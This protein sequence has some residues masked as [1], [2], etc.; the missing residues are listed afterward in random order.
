MKSPAL[1]LKTAAILLFTLGVLLLCTFYGPHQRR[2][3][4]PPVEREVANYVD[5]YHL[6][7]VARV[8]GRI[9]YL[10]D[11]RAFRSDKGTEAT[12]DNYLDLAV[13]KGVVRHV[14]HIV[15]ASAWPEVQKNLRKDPRFSLT[16]G[17]YVLPM[18]EGRLYVT[19]IDR[20]TAPPEK[21]MVVVNREVWSADELT[22]IKRLMGQG[23]LKSDL[24]VF[25]G[26][27]AGR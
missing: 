13:K 22:Q 10:F 5:I 4:A 1:V 7:E 26:E 24:A 14:F 23:G 19:T 18:E 2:Y 25:R 17:V 15:P 12:D 3:A 8:K 6:W 21:V 27:A 9:L 20:I 16:R 11:R